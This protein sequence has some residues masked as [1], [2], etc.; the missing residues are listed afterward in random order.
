VEGW[1]PAL[2]GVK[3]HATSAYPLAGAHATV[4]CA[5]CHI[6]AG[7]AT[8]YKV[9]FGQCADCHTDAHDG[10][11]ANAPFQDR[12]ETCHS[13]TDFHRSKFTIAMHR[14]TRYP[15]EGAHAVVPC[16]MCHKVGAGGRTDAVLPFHFEDQTC[17]ACH[18]DPHHGEFK[19]RMAQRGPN[20]MPLGCEA[21]HNV[22]SWIDAKGFDHSK[23]SFPLVGAHRAVACSACHLVPAGT[24]AAKLKGTSTVCEDCHADVHAGQFAQNNKTQCADCHNSER[25]APS[26]FDHDKRTSFPLTGGHANVACVQC[27]TQNRPVGGEA[28]LFYNLV[29][30]K[31][32]DCH[33]Q[34]KETFGPGK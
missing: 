16:D 3:Q 24:S 29:P 12:C 25:W 23:T 2:F 19:D 34:P 13:I 17:T 22:K 15:L 30:S 8:I 9:K 21:C 11:F 4:E 31:C 26:T 1:K 27:H 10:Q 6:P 18:V 14:D 5:K 32:A 20:G 33:G 7:V 28:V